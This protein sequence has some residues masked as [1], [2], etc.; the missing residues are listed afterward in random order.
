MNIP[1]DI[2]EEVARIYGYDNIQTLPLMSV[3]QYVPYTDAV[4]I[5]RKVE[6]VL[7]RNFACNQVETYPRVSEKEIKELGGDS[8]VLY[9]LQNPTNPE[10]PYLRAGMH[11]ELLAHTAKNSKFFDDFKIFDIGKVRNTKETKEQRNKELKN[12]VPELLKS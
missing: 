1:E 7:V 5:Q 12:I 6:D 3:A 2:Y 4:M 10:K 11:Y 9:K 8:T